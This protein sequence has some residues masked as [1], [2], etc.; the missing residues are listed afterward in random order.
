M[1]VS[2]EAAKARYGDEGNEDGVGP[3]D[4]TCQEAG[5]MLQTT[6]KERLYIFNVAAD[7]ESRCL[8]SNELP[9]RRSDHICFICGSFQ[10]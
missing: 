7:G 4:S 6:T 8:A 3:L 1:L 2:S 9:G 10:A 5:G